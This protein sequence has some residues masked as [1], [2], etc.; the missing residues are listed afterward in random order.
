MS[1]HNNLFLTYNNSGRLFRL[2]SFFCFFAFYGH[3][4][5]QIFL[6][7]DLSVPQY[8]S[9]I[10]TWLVKDQNNPRGSHSLISKILTYRWCLI[11][12]SQGIGPN[13]ITWLHLISCWT[14]QF[15]YFTKGGK[16]RENRFLRIADSL[17]HNKDDTLTRCW[18]LIF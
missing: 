1:W 2:A 13:S 15:C 18:P 12:F 9:V 16:K 5:I 10:Y 8:L 7:S 11:I 4:E 14:M 17:C 3:L 6:I